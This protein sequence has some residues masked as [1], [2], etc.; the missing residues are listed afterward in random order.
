MPDGT[1]GVLGHGSGSSLSFIQ[2]ASDE[3]Y[4]IDNLVSDAGLLS[5]Y[6]WTNQLE[7]SLVTEALRGSA[8]E[9]LVAREWAGGHGGGG[10]EAGRRPQARRASSVR[11]LSVNSCCYELWFDAVSSPQGRLRCKKGSR[12]ACSAAAWDAL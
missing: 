4:G 12:R 6:L 3:R 10:R 1:G 11:V 9:P 8:E 2:R 5:C 7:F